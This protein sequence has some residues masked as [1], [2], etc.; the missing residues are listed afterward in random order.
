M[1]LGYK[2][3]FPLYDSIIIVI[4]SIEQTYVYMALIIMVK[5]TSNSLLSNPIEILERYKFIV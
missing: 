2:V 4:V 5:R 3:D 1:L